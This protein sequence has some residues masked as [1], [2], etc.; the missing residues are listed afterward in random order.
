MLLGA[1]AYIATNAQ[2][3][4]EPVVDSSVYGTLGTNLNKVVADTIAELEAGAKSS[5]VEDGMI[6][7]TA[8]SARD[9][10]DFEAQTPSPTSVEPEEANDVD[11]TSQD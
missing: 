6:S 1:N 9:D 2:L 7:E 11:E 5:K 8:V 4:P 10:E 3:P